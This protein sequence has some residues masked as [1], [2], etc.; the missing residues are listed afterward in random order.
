M[1]FGGD[2]QG[3]VFALQVPRD[4]R[5]AKGQCNSDSYADSRIGN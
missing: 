2:E 3:Q 5:N 1:F 4:I